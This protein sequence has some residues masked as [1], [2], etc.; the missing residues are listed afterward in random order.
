[1]IARFSEA[2]IPYYF[3]MHPNLKA[4]IDPR[5]P[6][7]ICTGNEASIKTFLEVYPQAIPLHVGALTSDHYAD[8]WH[9]TETGNKRLA[10]IWY[11][12]LKEKGEL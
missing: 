2:H 1:M 6:E 7:G 4:P 10:E 3:Y 11:G 8:G 5:V 9:L 12:I